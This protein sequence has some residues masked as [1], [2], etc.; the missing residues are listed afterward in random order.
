M[1][2][3]SFKEIYPKIHV[4]SNVLEDVDKVLDYLKETENQTE[5]T[6]LGPWRDWFVFGRFAKSY[7]VSELKNNKEIYIVKS[8]ADSFKK[9]SDH[10]IQYNGLLVNEDENIVSRNKETLPL[11]QYPSPGFAKYFKDSGVGLSEN[12]AM[13]FHTDFDYTSLKNDGYKFCISGVTYLNEDY[14]DGEIQFFVNGNLF[15]YKPKKGDIIVFP[16]GNPNF[17]ADN[18]EQYLH[19]A[20]VVRNGEK[21]MVRQYLM[22]YELAPDNHKKE[23]DDKIN[24]LGAEET[25]K[26][27]RNQQSERL[28]N[29]RLDIDN[30]KHIDI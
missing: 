9:A 30:G 7:M 17:L 4:Y 13:E 1:D 19:S 18:N 16:S 24:S 20:K 14:D 8:T 10:Y 25:L 23:W 28:A 27:Y 5:I 2:K 29:L 11:W 3:I 22:R 21:Y 26:F 12:K 6:A 15:K